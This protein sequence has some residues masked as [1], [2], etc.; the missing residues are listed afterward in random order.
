M[1]LKCQAILDE[2]CSNKETFEIMR[3]VIL[4][5][6]DSFKIVNANKLVNSI[7]ARIKSE[8]SLSG[9]LE[10]KGDKYNSLSD[11]T[12]IVG[13]RVVC[14]YSDEVDKMAALAIKRFDIDWEN[15][16]DKRKAY[17]VDQFGYMSLHYICRIP[18][19]VFYDPEHPMVNEYRFELQLRTTL[20]HTWASIYHDTGYKHDIE[21][22]QEYLRSL[23]RLAGLMELAD[24]EFVDIRTSLDDYRKKVKSVVKSGNFEEVELNADSFKAYIETG[25]FDDLNKRI[26]STNNMD[27]ADASL[28]SYLRAFKEAD[29]EIHTL[30]DLHRIVNENTDDAFKFAINQMSGQDID[31]ISRTAGINALLMVYVIKKGLGEAKL[32]YL[33]DL[34]FGESKS[35]LRM[36]K[37][38]YERGRQ[39]GL[40]D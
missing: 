13:A 12:D 27:I 39:M 10:L 33:L 35:H 4:K 32:S 8:K 5:E 15:S 23:N 3:R 31:I 19:N 28:T 18:K 7:E 20:Q 24:K 21:I 30:G 17:K 38:N 11:I 22:P 29:L 6:L 37:R 2:Y 26:A 34:I 16:I 40:T 1:N 9:K 25:V 36:A 14:F